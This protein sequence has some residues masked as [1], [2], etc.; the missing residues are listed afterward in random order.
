MFA[1][2]RN[3][4]LKN[5]E[6]SISTLRPRTSVLSMTSHGSPAQPQ[7]QHSSGNQFSSA[8]FSIFHAIHP[9][10]LLKSILFDSH[11]FLR[12]I[13]SLVRSSQPRLPPRGNGP[14]SPLIV[15]L[16]SPSCLS[17]PVGSDLR[18]QIN[19]YLCFMPGWQS[20]RVTR[21]EL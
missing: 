10:S 9:R 2:R 12:S 14:T 5:F 7:A 3:S 18:R 20:P 11:S 15:G 13:Q 21:G 8:S 17:H 16:L 19:G 1:G 4:S 6:V